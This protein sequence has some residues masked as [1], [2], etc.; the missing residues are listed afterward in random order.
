[1]K[2][3]KNSKRL[4]IKKGHQ[5]TKIEQDN[6]ENNSE[7]RTCRSIRSYHKKLHEK[8]TEVKKQGQ[9]DQTRGLEIHTE[10]INA[11]TASLL[12]DENLSL[13]APVEDEDEDGKKIG[14][15]D[16]VI[17]GNLSGLLNK[18]NTH[19]KFKLKKKQVLTIKLLL[20]IHSAIMITRYIL[21]NLILKL[22]HFFYNCLRK[23]IEVILPKYLMR[24]KMLFLNL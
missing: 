8:Q 5:K 7:L 23:V 21:M 24:R 9:D 18:D 11:I 19:A 6:T 17:S 15:I 4:Y 22:F 20:E 14:S 3:L 10:T 2:T 1:M 13:E 16:V 12:E